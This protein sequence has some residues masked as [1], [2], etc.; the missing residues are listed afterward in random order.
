M[1][2]SVQNIALITHATI[3]QQGLQQYNIEQLLTDSRKLL[4]SD[5]SLFFALPGLGRN[6]NTYISSL[7][8][9]GVVSF[10]VDNSFDLQQ[11]KDYPNASF[12]QVP[13]VL[14]ALQQLAAYHRNIFSYPVIGITGSNGKTM[15]KEW[16]NHL[17][18]NT[19]NIVRSP[20]SYNSQIGVA[21]SVW[22]MQAVHTLG[23]FES[24]ISQINEMQQ[25]EQIIKPQIGIITFIG[26][27]HAEGFTNIEQKINEKLQLFTQAEHLIYCIDDKKLH[28]AVTVFKEHKNKA[29]SLFTWSK[30]EAATL[31]IENIE[32]KQKV[33]NIIA[34]FENNNFYFCIPFVDDASIHNAITCC[35]TMLLLGISIEEICASMQTLRPVEMRL[36]LKQGINNCSI[37][38]DSYSADVQSL[39][40]SL[41][42]LEQQ[43]QQQYK[44]VILSDV[45]QT[46]KAGAILYEKIAAILH[47][48]NI[49]QFIGIGGEI[50]ANATAFKNIKNTFFYPSTDNFLQ[51][52][53]E[54]HFANQTILLKGARVFR[55][56]KIS[57]ALEQKIH[58]TRLEINLHALRNNLQVYKNL[59]QPDVKIMAMVKAFSYGSGG[60]EIA[61]V[62]QHAGVQYLAVAYT[63]EA[64]ELRQAGISLPLMVM[65][66]EATSYDNIIKYNVEPE[67]FSVSML[68]EFINYLIS[69]DIE[70][71]PIHIKI[72]TGM[73]R[74]G[75][76]QDQISILC[77]LL[78]ENNCIKVVSI[79]SHLAASDSSTFDNFTEQ[80]TTIFLQAANQIKEA[81]GYSVL[82]HIS[83]SSAIFRHPNLQLNMVRLGIGLYGIDATPKV[84]QR[85]EPV[86]TLKTTIAQIKQVAKGQSVG[87]SRKG[88][89]TQQS[90]IATVRIGYADGYPRALSNGVG[91]MFIN[92]NAAPVIG[93]V[94]MDMTML[95]V[96]GLDVSEGDE[97]IVFGQEPTVST[98]AYWANTISYEILT[99][100]SQRVKRVY[101]EE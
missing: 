92:G 89:T 22:R 9:K 3:L 45:L 75:F 5:T 73:H 23:I 64:V 24:G 94:C 27:A 51:H 77:R 91:K 83:N 6:G 46:G 86:A 53:Q 18:G 80:Q 38:N 1:N 12:L 21:L 78:K 69:H 13:N 74:L 60:V 34:N 15:V 54:H 65:N 59:L 88:V 48:K 97:V 96:T 68:Q 17:L 58:Q 37:I 55:F 20:K 61:N 50:Q 44:T 82:L 8:K 7:Y 90:S 66:V 32:K 95:D 43:N 36:E 30:N 47:S 14:K 39:S 25:L 70:Q 98:L 31:K 49:H 41:D 42:F 76:E 56:E 84:Q 33:T 100:I 62:L 93:N 2:Y 87:Y 11:L 57:Q 71:F 72:D 79:F 4:F 10:V 35:C 16:L 81:L 67:V 40:I 85:L 26:S 63:D 101:Y 99:G 52:V 28:T 19:Y 29:L